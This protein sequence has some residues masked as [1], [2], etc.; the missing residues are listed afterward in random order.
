MAKKILPVLSRPGD[1][2]PVPVD[3]RVQQITRSNKTSSWPLFSALLILGLI[4]LI[5]ASSLAWSWLRNIKIAVN[6]ASAPV[7]ALTLKVQRTA[8]YAGLEYT[9]VNAQYAPSFA[10]DTIHAGAGVVRL[11]M[12][13]AN[14][15]RDQITIVYYDIAR[16][17]APKL[18]PIAPSNIDLSVGPRPGTSESG[19][20]DFS[21]PGALPLDTL[22]L[23]LGSTILG[24]SLVTIPFTGPF[25][26]GRYSDR[27]SQQS[28]AIDYYFPYY[29]RQLLIYHLTSVDIR[30]SYRGSQA[31]AGQQYYVLNFS[32]D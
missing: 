17:L 24:E 5:I 26:A 23:Q 25:D 22:K 30:Y 19:W 16:L 1:K 14:K 11:N 2:T 10:D 13:V 12:L 28:L 6:P 15:S 8:P 20:L 31:K 27:T 7:P 18:N 9:I 32:V 3:A 29:R 4:I 21:V